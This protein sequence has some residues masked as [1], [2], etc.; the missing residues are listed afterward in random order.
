[1]V[2]RTRR[3]MNVARCGNHQ[4]AQVC[5]ERAGPTPFHPEPGRATA[6][7]QGYWG[8]DSLGDE[9]NAPVQALVFTAG[10]HREVAVSQ[11]RT[12]KGEGG[13]ACE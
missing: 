5:F 11:Y 4:A 13:D 2:K 7:R 6:Q 9:V 8:D 12:L 1:M 3:Q 10:R